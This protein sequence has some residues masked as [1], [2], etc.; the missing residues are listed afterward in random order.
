LDVPGGTVVQTLEGHVRPV[1]HLA[2]SADGGRLATAS[3]DAADP[4]VR[5]WDAA[6]GRLAATIAAQSAVLGVSFAAAGRL[7]IAAGNK[8]L[9]HD[10]DA[11]IALEGHTR[12]VNAVAFDPSGAR[13]VTAS[14]DGT[15]RVWDAGTGK[16]L[17]TLTGHSSGVAAAAFDPS[18]K[19]II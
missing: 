13:A 11:T 5:V 16:L 3:A 7:A 17:V 8:A 1:A 2:W 10:G 14:G 18:G 6:S 4:T 12:D 9:L 19:T 15:A